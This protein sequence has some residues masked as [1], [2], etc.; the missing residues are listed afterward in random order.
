MNSSH[1]AEFFGTLFFVYIVLATGN[2]IAIGAALALIILLTSGFK[3][4]T[5][6][7][8]V[9]ITLAAAG[10]MPVSDLLPRLI[11]QVLGGLIAYELYKR[12]KI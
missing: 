2:A 8:A 3:Y 1:L 9:S 7:P 10:K 6:N 12:V 4:V 5:V 11:I